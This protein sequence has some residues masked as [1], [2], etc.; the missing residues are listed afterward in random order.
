MTISA[1]EGPLKLGLEQMQFQS[2]TSQWLTPS[3]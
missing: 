1:A 3:F 2:I